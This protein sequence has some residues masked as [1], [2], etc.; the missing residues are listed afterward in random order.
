MAVTS[1][2]K[3]AKDN[4]TEL[5]LQI[6]IFCP[7]ELLTFKRT[8]VQWFHVQA[9]YIYVYMHMLHVYMH[10]HIYVGSGNS[11]VW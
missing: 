11:R 8:V 5:R 9:M 10:I 4:G 1:G 2:E 6:T 3:A 7:S